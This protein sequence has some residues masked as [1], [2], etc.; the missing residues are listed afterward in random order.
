MRLI[1]QAGIKEY[2]WNV[3]MFLFYTT[4]LIELSITV[5][6]IKQQI[7]NIQRMMTL[8]IE[9]RTK[10]AHTHTPKDANLKTYT[11]IH[12][13]ILEWDQQQWI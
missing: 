9:S 7:S 12:I 3:Q 13:S 8:M 2:E 6:N 4:Q 5:E 10:N 11:H 1:D